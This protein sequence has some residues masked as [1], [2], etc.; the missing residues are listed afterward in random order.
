MTLWID[1]DACPRAVREIVFRAAERVEVKAVLVANRALHVPRSSWIRAVQVPRS[2]D[3]ADDHIRREASPGD[4]VVTDDIPLA[5]T[6]VVRGVHAV[7]PRG[8]S[9]DEDN[10]GERLAMRDL[11]AGL[12]DAGTITGGPALFGEADRRRL[13]NALDRLLTRKRPAREG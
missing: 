12:R 11:F 1:G 13:A 5:A 10:I 2:F 9:F 4:I 3:A 8:E 7:S 6:L